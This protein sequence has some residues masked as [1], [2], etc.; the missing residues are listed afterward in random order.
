M[1]IGVLVKLTRPDFARELTEILTWLNERGCLTLVAED[2][3]RELELSDTDTAPRH[4]L[5]ELSDIL[6]VFGG[7][8]TLL[9]A[10]RLVGKFST[11][12]LGVNLGTLGFLTETS[13]EDLIPSLE[14]LLAGE[15]RISRRWKL[16]VE[17][18]RQKQSVASFEALNDAVINKGALARIISLEAYSGSDFIA[19]FLAD[20]LI[21]ATPTGSTAYSLAAG[22][23]ILFPSES[24]IAITPICPHTLTN[25]PLI[26]PATNQVR[27]LLR[28][29]DE[30]MLTVDG[31]VGCAMQEGDELICTRSEKPIELI[32]PGSTTFFDILRQKLKWGER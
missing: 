8:G 28:S 1:R 32:Q 20:G 12:I 22:G 24:L 19:N 9:S 30:V 21:V 4:Q 13:R 29:G 7:D 31:Q 17:L 5:P 18:R 10:A 11:P 23:P 14:R 6:L 2:V 15:Y 25:R 16:A 27:V 3:A 26:L